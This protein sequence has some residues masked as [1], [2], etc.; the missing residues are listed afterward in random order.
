[1]IMLKRFLSWIL[2][3]ALALG[4]FSMMG[5]AAEAGDLY[6]LDKHTVTEEIIVD[7]P[8]DIDLPENEELFDAFAEREFFGYDMATFGRSARRSLSDVEAKIYDT[9]KLKIE[10]IAVK[11]GKTDITI[12]DLGDLKTTWTNEELGVVSIEDNSKISKE[13]MSQFDNVKIITALISDC[14]FDLYWFDKTAGAKVSLQISATGYYKGSKVTYDS[15]T[16][17]GLSYYF[18]VSSDYSA[19]PFSVTKKVSKINTVKN[20]AMQVVKSNAKKSDYEKLLA[21]KDYICEAVSYNYDAWN[22]K[23][24]PYGDT[25]QLIYV[26][27]G[28]ASTNV[29]CEGYAKAFQYLCDLTTFSGEVTCIS[30]SGV[31]DEQHM[32]NVVTLEGK[33][34]LVD[35]TNSDSGMSGQK[36][37]L[38]L[39]GGPGSAANGYRVDGL[40]Y[41][42]DNQVKSM[43]GTGSDSILTLSS[44]KYEPSKEEP[45]EK[46]SAPTVKAT[47]VES[48]GKIKLTW[49]KIKNAKEYEV[50]RATSKSGTYKLL[51]TVTGTSLT[52]T[53]VDAGKTYY[54]KVRAVSASGVKSK[55]SSVVSRTCDLAQPKVTVSNVASSG[56]IKIS[57]EK[58]SGATK[59]EV[60]RATSKSGT[61]KL[62]K[63]VTG[64]SLTN[65]S[66]D[67]GKTYYYKVKAIHSTS[68]A[69]SAYSDVVS[70][71][72]DLARPDVTA[73][74]SSGKVKLTW[75]KIS[76]ATEYKV[77][78]ATSKDG[79]Y[80]L[81]KTTT[82]ASYTDKNVTS[83]KTYYYKVKAIHKTS[84][85]NS[86]YS[87][88]DSIKVK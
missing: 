86:A 88:I 72:C 63:T 52:N 50:Y 39:A 7:I 37:G 36:G 33:N 26:F 55:F 76:G 1:M 41:I 84:A 61:Y 13:F 11:G 48:T 28:D 54:Y 40:F 49:N 70:R 85:A 8:L 53:S 69:N 31:T 27:D 43:Y 79:T 22:D 19:G 10:D 44:K 75:G 46:V 47:N 2:C 78:R 23:R 81:V 32:W 24:A 77:Y 73:K 83:G 66:V 42:Y 56:K 59:Y 62:L 80:K 30:V 58:V 45:A 25:S 71:T 4:N 38:F 6:E 15:A 18:T 9:L 51:K 68:A 16:V 67:A 29:V 82:S 60:Y 34:Y 3:M 17:V 14:P 5:F 35:V 57:W 12:T 74:L 87:S 64:T 20:N 65:T 21:Y